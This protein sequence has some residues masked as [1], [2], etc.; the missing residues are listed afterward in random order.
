MRP[1]L[2]QKLSQVFRSKIREAIMRPTERR[3]PHGLRIVVRF[4]ANRLAATYLADAYEQ[5]LPTKRRSVRVDHPAAGRDDARA[6][7]RGGGRCA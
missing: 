3:I 5:V 2:G 4:E 7:P 6:A 1:W